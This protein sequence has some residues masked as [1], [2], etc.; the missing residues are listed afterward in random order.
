MKVPRGSTSDPAHQF[1]KQD[2]ANP[3]KNDHRPRLP[4]QSVNQLVQMRI[5]HA[6]ESSIFA[7]FRPPPSAFLPN[8]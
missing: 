7:A 3:A 1:P 8:H 2:Y 4:H 5:G 6:K